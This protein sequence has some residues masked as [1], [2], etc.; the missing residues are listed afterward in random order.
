MGRAKGRA[1]LLSMREQARRGHG[2]LFASVEDRC[3]CRERRFW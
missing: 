1:L 2:G 3:I